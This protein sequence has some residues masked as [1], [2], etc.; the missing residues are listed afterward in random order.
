MSLPNIRAFIISYKGKNGFLVELRDPI[1][2]DETYC[3]LLKRDASEPVFF[4]MMKAEEC[5][6][7]RAGKV[8]E[9]HNHGRFPLPSVIATQI[10]RLSREIF[11][12]EGTV[13]LG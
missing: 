7:L 9:D 12:A 11:P 4:G 6:E 13:V 2:Q 5:M 8:P 3:Y 10:R 1:Y